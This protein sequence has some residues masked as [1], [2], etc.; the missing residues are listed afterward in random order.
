MSKHFK[1]DEAADRMD[2]DIEDDDY[3]IDGDDEDTEH[4][5]SDWY[6]KQR[7]LNDNFET[8]MFNEEIEF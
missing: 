4:F 5:N 7:Y 6:Q 2:D 1:N 8:E 3:G